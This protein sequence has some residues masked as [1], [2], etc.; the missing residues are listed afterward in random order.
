MILKWLIKSWPQD[1]PVRGYFDSRAAEELHLVKSS[2]IEWVEPSI[3]G[4][5]NAELSLTKTV[6]HHDVVVF[7]NSL[8]PLL[9][10]R[11][12]VVVFMQNRNFIDP[13][14]LLT[15]FKLL[16][17]LRIAVEKALAYVFRSRVD[18]YVVQTASFKTLLE[19]WYGGGDAG[20][21]VNVTLFPFMD[22]GDI[23]ASLALEPPLKKHDFIY[24]ADGLGHKNHLA[25]LQAWEILADLNCYPQVGRYSA[26]VGDKSAGE[27]LGTSK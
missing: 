8:P 18:E 9:S 4:R 5:L 26:C 7:F 25:L 10:C 27:D 6:S 2:E 20:R 11:G 14:S 15:E 13:I 23:L 3:L 24:V 21:C 22:S 17:A 1:V 19:K 12:R 16:Q